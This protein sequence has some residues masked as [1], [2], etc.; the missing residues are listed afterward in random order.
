MVS[1]SV[2]SKLGVAVG[3]VVFS[4]VGDFVGV[5]LGSAV[6]WTVADGR[7]VCVASREGVA[8]ARPQAVTNTIIVTI[9]K[10]RRCISKL[11]P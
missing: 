6:G 10:A 1:V 8:V 2:G 4:G 3:V 11:Y 9:I 5:P 7:L